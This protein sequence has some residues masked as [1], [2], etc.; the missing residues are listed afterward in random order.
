MGVITTLDLLGCVSLNFL[1]GSVFWGIELQNS[2]R[3]HL[4]QYLNRPELPIHCST[5]NPNLIVQHVLGLS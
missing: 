4:R 3:F 5:A 2:D 1:N